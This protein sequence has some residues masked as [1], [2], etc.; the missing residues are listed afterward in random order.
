MS[1]ARMLI[2][3]AVLFGTSTAFAYNP[4]KC[5]SMR[6]KGGFF[7]YTFGGNLSTDNMTKKHG[8]VGST[9]ESSIQTAQSLIDP[10]VIIG[11]TSSTVQFSSSFG[12]C[13]YLGYNEEMRKEYVAQN[14]EPMKQQVA[15]GRGEHL[16]SLYHYS[17]CQDGAFR[18]FRA[19]LQKDYSQLVRFKTGDENAFLSR[20]DL[21]IFSQQNLRDF[22]RL[23]DAA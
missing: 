3:F 19:A 5:F 8:T 11:S 18:D 21:I 14:I 22:C 1:I 2:L 16:R 6:V 20:T 17:N 13:S 10:S 7:K 9:Y 4:K 23:F 12:A 15:F